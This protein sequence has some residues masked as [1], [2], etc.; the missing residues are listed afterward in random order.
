M[1]HQQVYYATICL[2]CYYMFTMLL[3]K[4]ES[5]GIYTPNMI[6]NL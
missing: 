5:L 4:S 2:L 3:R 6:L 1:S